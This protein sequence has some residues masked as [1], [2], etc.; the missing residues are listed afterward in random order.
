LDLKHPNYL[1]VQTSLEK[2]LYND[3][4]ENLSEAGFDII[5][6][7]DT[8]YMVCRYIYIKNDK[9]KYSLYLSLVGKY[10]IL[11]AKIKNKFSVITLED[12]FLELNER[13][14]LNM[15]SENN[16]IA[17]D[18]Q[19]LN[20]NVDFYPNHCTDYDEPTVYNLLFGDDIP[21]WQ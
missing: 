2:G 3:I 19:I 13:L 6:D 4:I 18:I 7:T 14:I 15:L 1:F 11:L 16:I 8:N 5:E 20:E 17:L 9:I 21:P 10:S 12:E